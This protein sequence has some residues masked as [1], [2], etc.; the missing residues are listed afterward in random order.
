MLA[1][2]TIQKVNIE[3]LASAQSRSMMHVEEKLPPESL[4]ITTTR[5]KCTCLLLSPPTG[6]KIER[7]PNAWR[8]RL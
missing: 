5:P 8:R 6:C 7:H 2:A 4:Y 3:S 1:G